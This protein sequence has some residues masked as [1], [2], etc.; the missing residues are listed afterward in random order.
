MEADL[1]IELDTELDTELEFQD[2]AAS[3]KGTLHSPNLLASPVAHWRSLSPGLED[4][5][6][7]EDFGDLGD[8]EDLRDL[9]DLRDLGELDRGTDCGFGTPK[10]LGLREFDV[11]DPWPAL[12]TKAL[13]H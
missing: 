13:D 4:L 11:E 7:F 12:S 6:G 1:T 10:A 3:P 2:L 8:L 5:G 9:R